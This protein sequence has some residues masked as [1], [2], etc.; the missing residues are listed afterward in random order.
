MT[1]NFLREQCLKTL[2]HLLTVHQRAQQN[3]IFITMKDHL[4]CIKLVPGTKG[5]QNINKCGRKFPIKSKIFRKNS[6]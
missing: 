5:T 6:K 4:L 1:K 3:L 2:N